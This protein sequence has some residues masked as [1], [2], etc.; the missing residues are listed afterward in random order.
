MKEIFH[1]F[2]TAIIAIV[3]A[4][5]IIGVLFG[6]SISG[7]TGILKIAGV[8]VE[9]EEIDFTSYH[10]FDSVV[11]WHNRT[12]PVAA[13]TESYGRFFALSNT[14][15]LSRYYAKDMEGSTM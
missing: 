1:E 13:Y 8:S 7:K 14:S 15:F 12:K 11:S 4:V 10:D 5:L 2:G 3:T 6:I 9:K